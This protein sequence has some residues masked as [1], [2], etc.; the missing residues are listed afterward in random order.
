MVSAF[1]FDQI[2]RGLQR[3]GFLVRTRMGQNV[4]D[5]SDRNNS[6]R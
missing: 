4:E 2:E 3:P 6:R 1:P 5:I